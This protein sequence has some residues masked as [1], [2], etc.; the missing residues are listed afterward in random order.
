MRIAYL[1]GS[2]NRGGTETLLL[3]VF[4]NAGKNNLD[5]IGIYRKSGVLEKD[6]Q[7][8]G[9]SL[10]KV[11]TGKGVISYIFR[12]RKLLLE[13]NVTITHAQ[14]PIDALYAKLA[15]LGTGIKVM[16][17][18]HGYDF[19]EKKPAKL[20]LRFI[21]HR[22]DMNIYVSDSQRQYNQEKYN[23]KPGKQKVVY[24]GISFDKLNG[25]DTWTA[26]KSRTPSNNQISLH[27]ELQLP[28]SSLLLG[29]VG[30]F[31]DVR[32]QMTICRFLK[33][34]LEKEV[35]FYFVFV[36]KRIDNA[37]WL[38]DNCLDFCKSNGLSDSV[39]FLGVRNDVPMI[40]NELDAFVY[41]TN[42]D[43]F[44]IAVV[45][46]MAA[47]IPVFVNDW[48]VMNE[49]TNQGKYA[50]LY[51][52]KDEEDLLQQFML[53]LQNKALYQDNAKEAALF[54]RER[55][56]IEKHIEELKKVYNKMIYNI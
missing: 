10:H 2:L 4:R 27:D 47:G 1:L 7:E 37:T 20:L 32:D 53:F 49:I 16:L 23:L 26:T 17:T 3:D 52:T 45:E 22:I 15:C 31:N 41:S 48:D 24:N 54:V 40:L 43:T 8:S 56:S 28:S 34:L 5:A 19:S 13:N 21:I 18:L 35:N 44:G 6:F 33:L 14:Q 38:Y 25:F 51:K 55:Y 12:L 50:T 36:G 42:H 39:Y 46:A 30:N 9:L 11:S 29:A